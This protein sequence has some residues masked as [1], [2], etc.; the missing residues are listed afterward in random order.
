MEKVR[1]D[2]VLKQVKNRSY[3]NYNKG[4][5]CFRNNSISKA[6]SYYSRAIYLNDN[7]PI[8]YFQKAEAYMLIGQTDN[9]IANYIV[10]LKKIKDVKEKQKLE[11]LNNAKQAEENKKLVE[12][13]LLLFKENIKDEGTENEIHNKELEN[14]KNLYN[15]ITDFENTEIKTT[16]ESPSPIQKQKKNNKEKNKFKG[17]EKETQY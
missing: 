12:N 17:K 4:N 10:C 2:L 3:E 1:K 13:E 14:M 6:I 8:F 5:E 15:N 16:N 7:E 9:A 11:E